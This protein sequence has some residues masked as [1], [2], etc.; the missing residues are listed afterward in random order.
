MKAP[1]F[2]H[3]RGPPES[4]LQPEE[5]PSNPAQKDSGP[6]NALYRPHFELTNNKFYKEYI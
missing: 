4:P 3:I 1:L 5:S 6:S 2:S